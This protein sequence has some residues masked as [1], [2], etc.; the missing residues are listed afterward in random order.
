MADEIDD[1]VDSPVSDGDGELNHREC[2]HCLLVIRLD[3]AKPAGTN[4]V[5]CPNCGWILPRV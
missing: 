1:P 3:E 4:K 2:P 5:R